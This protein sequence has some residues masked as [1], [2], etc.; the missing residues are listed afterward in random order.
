MDTFTATR[1]QKQASRDFARDVAGWAQIMAWLVM[2]GSII[3]GMVLAS[4]TSGD[5][6]DQTRPYVGLGFA[7]AVSGVVTGLMMLLVASVA[8]YL[9]TPE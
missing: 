5:F 1:T 9:T 4:Q 2:G 6:M 7:T 3:G 8:V